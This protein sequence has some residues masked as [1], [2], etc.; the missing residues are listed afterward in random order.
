MYSKND[1]VQR[2]CSQFLVIGIQRKIVF[3]KIV[4]KRRFSSDRIENLYTFP[5]VH[6]VD[7]CATLKL[8]LET[9]M[10]LYLCASLLRLSCRHCRARPVAFYKLYSVKKVF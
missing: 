2:E 7:Q 1:Q 9:F 3:E 10:L 4:V 5:T 6:V 8:S